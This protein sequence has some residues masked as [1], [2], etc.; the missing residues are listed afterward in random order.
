MEAVLQM[1]HNPATLNCHEAVRESIAALQT[2]LVNLDGVV[3]KLISLG[4]QKVL[5][6]GAL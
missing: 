5:V 1:L 4:E 6:F 3:D 2:L